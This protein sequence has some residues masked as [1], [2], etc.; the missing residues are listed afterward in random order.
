MLTL[1]GT[2]QILHP[3]S[4]PVL[5][6]KPIMFVGADVTHA[7][8]GEQGAKPSIA[9]MVASMDPSC[10]VYNAE[11]RL[12]TPE[13]FVIILKTF[14]LHF[15]LWKISYFRGV[16]GVVEVITDAEAMLKTLLLNFYKRNGRKP[17]KIIYYRDGVSEG[18]FQDVLNRELSAFQRA[19]SS[20]ENGYQPGITF[21]V[22]QKRHKTRLFPQNPQKDGV[23]RNK[24]VPPGTVVDTEI[25]NPTEDSF[26]L[27][28][29][30]GIQV[31]YQIYRENNTLGKTMF[32]GHISY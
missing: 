13:R 3:S 18:Q 31:R 27:A 15:K 20:L 28:S 24:N 22:A 7:A 21:I 30:E 10:S 11:I 8:P 17:E 4:K 2:N 14:Y 29:H 26:F 25:T 32:I 16:F 1:G 12:Q 6:Q 23:G 19:C 9:A 5:F